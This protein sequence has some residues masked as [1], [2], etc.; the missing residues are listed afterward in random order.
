MAPVKEMAMPP[1]P[2]HIPSSITDVSVFVSEEVEVI[3]RA[4]RGSEVKG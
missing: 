4:S 2:L 1:P 3:E